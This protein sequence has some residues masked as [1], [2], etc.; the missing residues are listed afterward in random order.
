MY[1]SGQNFKSKLFYLIED[2]SI[3]DNNLFIQTSEGNLIIELV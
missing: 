2:F 1:Y 3:K